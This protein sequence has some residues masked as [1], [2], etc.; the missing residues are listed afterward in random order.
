L[1]VL[2]Q[3][4]NEMNAND[5]TMIDVMFV[6][7]STMS[8]VGQGLPLCQSCFEEIRCGYAIDTQGC[9]DWI[10]NSSQLR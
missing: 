6:V 1:Y 4:E 2:L 3:P 10:F 7:N 8:L 9:W 5:A